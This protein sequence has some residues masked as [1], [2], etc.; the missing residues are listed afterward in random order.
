[1]RTAGRRLGEARALRPPGLDKQ[2]WAAKRKRAV[3]TALEQ[4]LS[5]GGGLGGWGNLLDRWIQAG[6]LRTSPGGDVSGGARFC[7]ELGE[8]LGHLGAVQGFVDA[9]VAGGAVDLC[10]IALGTQS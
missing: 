5:G 4:P 2:T 9:L 10:H 1:M 6:A 8:I 7:P 3:G